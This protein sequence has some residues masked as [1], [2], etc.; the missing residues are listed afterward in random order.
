MLAVTGMLNELAHDLNVSIGQ[1]GQLNAAF[2]IAVAVSAPLLGIVT[3]RI[4][5]RT[6]LLAAMTLYALL[7]FAAA[8]APGFFAL[9][10]LRFAA[11]FAP[12]IYTPQAAGTAGLLVP[13]ER[14]GTAISTVFL[15]F[16]VATV[17][18]L[19]LGTYVGSHFGWRTMMIIVACMS[20]GMMIWLRYTLPAKLKVA[21][22]DLRAFADLGRDNT[23]LLLIGVTASQSAAQFV[24]FSYIAPALKIFVGA[25]PGVLGLLLAL[26]GVFGVVG[27]TLAAR[28]M[29]RVG[30]ARIV[31]LALGSMLLAMLV[32]PLSIGNMAITALAVSL[33]GLGCFAVNSAQQVLLVSRNPRLAPVSVAFNSSALYLG[34]AIGTV[35]GAAIIAQ[36]SLS[37]L[38]WA[39]VM[40]FLVAIACSLLAARTARAAATA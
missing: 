16:S 21:P 15:G 23:L 32:W 37:R 40:I 39:G 25:T 14:R 19:P 13:P 8:L 31:M 33:W 30:P 18:G 28:F 3:S 12:A 5:R 26:F 1:A 9:L 34:Q 7:H 11:G 29:D 35:L 17:V 24:L 27:N 36:W 4:D 10:I 6:L 38:S 20:I 22:L 2:A